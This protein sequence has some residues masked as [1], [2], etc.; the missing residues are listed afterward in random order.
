MK[1]IYY[2]F[3]LIILFFSTLNNN[4]SPM[5]LKEKNNFV[6]SLIFEN[7]LEK[8]PPSI[9]VYYYTKKYCKEFNIPEKRFFRILRKETTYS[10][11]SHINYNPDQISSGN[12][13]GPSQL[14]LSTARDMY[15]LLGL[16][17]RNELTREMLLKDIELNL[18]LGIRYTRWLR[19]QQTNW[20]KIAGYYNTGYWIINDYAEYVG[21]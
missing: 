3:I 6:E 5:S 14:L 20:K 18:K 4:I 16:G 7:I 10:G 11:P 9:Q 13:L 15:V 19:D 21:K 12:A 2:T 1:L 8:S 17:N